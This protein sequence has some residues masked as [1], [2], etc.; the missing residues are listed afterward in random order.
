[1]VRDMHLDNTQ[2]FVD[3]PEKHLDSSNPCPDT[4]QKNLSLSKRKATEY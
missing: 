4:E 1:M 3:I 2:P